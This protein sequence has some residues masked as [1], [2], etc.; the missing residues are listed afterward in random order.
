[1]NCESD[2]QPQLRVRSCN[3]LEL[4]NTCIFPT[5]LPELIHSQLCTFHIR[6]AC[7]W[8]PN[9]EIENTNHSNHWQ[10]DLTKLYQLL[11]NY[12]DFDFSSKNPKDSIVPATEF[13]YFFFFFFLLCYSQMNIFR[14]WALEKC[15]G[16]FSLLRETLDV[17]RLIDKW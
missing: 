5:S 12:F 11:L 13:A 8:M 17:M 1:M 6:S 14:C 9:E 7:I 3:I 16:H 10:V 15:D 4:V 2:G